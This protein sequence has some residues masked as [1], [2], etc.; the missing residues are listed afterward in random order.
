M[1]VKRF[2]QMRL[3]KVKTD[4]ADAKL[5]CLYAQNIELRLWEGESKNRRECA[6]IIR[7]INSYFKQSTALKNKI[8]GEETLGNPS[9]YVVRSLK[10]SLKSIQKE[11]KQLELKL[12]ELVKEEHQDLLTIIETITGIGRRTASMLIVLTDG[13]RR[14]ESASQLCS[15]AGITPIIRESGSSIR[16][17]A[18]ISKMGNQKLRNL[19]FLCS[20]TAC[21]HNKACKEIYERMIAK[22]KSKKVA[23]M[24]VCNK[25][26]KQ[27]FAIAKS[28]LV[29][30]ENFRSKKPVLN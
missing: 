8:H 9:S 18:R 13:F 17:K 16:G 30:D 20:F 24:A 26:L 23:L 28:G 10:R 29:Y 4:K 3:S 15:F 22:G 12:T 14:F 27:A 21:Q 11:I 19:L 2:G 25:L 5:I 7:L 6:Q 1:S